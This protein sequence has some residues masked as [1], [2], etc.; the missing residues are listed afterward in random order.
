[1]KNLLQARPFWLAVLC[2]LLVAGLSLP[3]AADKPM[4]P[5]KV[6]A[7]IHQGSLTIFPVVAAT[8]HDTAQFLTLDDGLSSGEVVVTES[9]HQTSPMV[10]R[11]QVPRGGGAQVNRLALINNSDRPLLLLAGEI[12]TG[13]KQDRV[14][15]ADRIVPPGGE[16]V[17]LSVF[18][19][20]P[21][22]WTGSSNHFG[23]LHTLMAQP[24][25]RQ[26]AM[27]ERNQQLVWDQVR[28]SRAAILAVAPA[29][30]SAAP[31]A[32]AT[33]S[34]AGTMAIPEVE[35]QVDKVAEPLTRSYEDVLRQLREHN[36]VGVVVAIHGR[37]EWVD[38]FA[39][40]AL[41][42][43]Y[44]PKLVRS[45]AAEGLTDHG[46]AGK[47]PDID[48]A[49]RFLMNMKGERETS[50][51]EEDLY[52]ETEISGPGWKAFRLTSLLPKTGY[53][54]H[55]AKMTMNDSDRSELIGPGLERRY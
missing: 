9:G 7:P 1:M 21:G 28:S 17:D 26:Q 51:T 39:S 15:G 46:E 22:R 14:I 31:G 42:Q 43:K 45:Y 29:A 48:G 41:L 52:R 10:R 53:D 37:L 49:Q 32:G 30:P 24:S 6:L 44:W 54:V 12:V 16:P 55:V 18:C 40:E 19:V 38:L 50:Q 27:A 25:V 35:K 23:S 33:T 47:L 11:G 2:L 3:L 13:G 34:Y 20:E 4:A 5:Y 8:M 36:A